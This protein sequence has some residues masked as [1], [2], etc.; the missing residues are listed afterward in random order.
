MSI[1][2]LLGLAY[3]AVAALLLSLN[4]QTKYRREI[5][6]AAIIA[7]SLLY[8]GAYHG[9][10]NLRGWA[11]S[12]TPPN[13]FK[14][15]WA[16]VEEPDKVNG[17]QGAIYILGQSL[18]ARGVTI[19]EPRLFRLPFSPELAEQVDD[20]LSKKE[21]GRDLEARLSYKAA[22]PDEFDEIQRRDGQKA[23]P[24][25]AGEEDRLKLNFRELP[26]PDLPL[27]G[28]SERSEP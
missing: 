21:D 8:I 24:D 12:A 18:S 4:L 22:T 27:K 17:A 1:P 28:L 10:Q 11:I 13:P 14:L 25:S 9:T 6:L 2:L 19:G 7:V 16:V 20:A 26:S 23:R 5:K 15:H 3:A